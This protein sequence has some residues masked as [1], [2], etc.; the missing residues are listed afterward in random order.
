MGT[1]GILL[2][3]MEGDSVFFA[4]NK[5]KFDNNDKIMKKEYKEIFRAEEDE[6]FVKG[7]FCFMFSEPTKSYPK[8]ERKASEKVQR[9][10]YR[11]LQKEFK[12]KVR[13]TK[14]YLDNVGK[15]DMVNLME[16]KKENETRKLKRMEI[17]KQ[18]QKD[19][20]FNQ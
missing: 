16:I 15:A 13:I 18:K 9:K 20:R 7:W 5:E 2:V 12:K 1:H 11:R 17:Q 8:K 3:R 14:K 6:R 19:L 10:L 4:Y